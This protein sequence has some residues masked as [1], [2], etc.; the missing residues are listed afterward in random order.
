VKVVRSLLGVLIGCG[1]F[2]ALARWLSGLTNAA[3]GYDLLIG[4]AGTVVAAVLAGYTA[5]FIGGAHEFPHAAAVGLFMVGMGFV[6]MMQEGATKPGWHQ[7]SVAGC[8]PISALIGAA[9]R[10]LTKSRRAG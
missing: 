7:I 10:L 6:S 3:P 8:G 1:L 4:V 9:I 2:F 5:A